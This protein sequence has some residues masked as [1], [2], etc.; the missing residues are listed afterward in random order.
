MA[1]AHFTTSSS[2][3]APVAADELCSAVAHFRN[4]STSDSQLSQ[5]SPEQRI[6]IAPL[7]CRTYNLHP[8]PLLNVAGSRAPPAET[9]FLPP[10]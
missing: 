9:V 4:L 8:P 6:V 10:P 5:A 3:P 2:S 1:V 7:A